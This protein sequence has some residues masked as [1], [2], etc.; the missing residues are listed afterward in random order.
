MG[1]PSKAGESLAPQ[2]Y[3]RHPHAHWRNRILCDDSRDNPHSRGRISVL[4]ETLLVID[5][6]RRT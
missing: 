2:L 3:A 5:A 1:T 4:D 6:G